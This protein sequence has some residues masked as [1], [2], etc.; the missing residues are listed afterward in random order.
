MKT[1]YI[2]LS[3]LMI[4]V[5]VAP[6]LAQGAPPATPIDGGLTALLAA[7]GLYGIKK[8]RDLRK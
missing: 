6:A 2:S 1:S 8:I 3:V 4:L 7:G 5:V